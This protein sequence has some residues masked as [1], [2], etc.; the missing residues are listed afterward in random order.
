MTKLPK[1]L[2]G[3][4]RGRS[5]TRRPSSFPNAYRAAVVRRADP[6]AEP[7]DRAIGDEF[8]DEEMADAETDGA[9]DVSV[10]LPSKRRKKTDGEKAPDDREPREHSELAA[11]PK[12][13]LSPREELHQL[14]L[15][16]VTGHSELQEDRDADAD[17]Q[18]AESRSDETRDKRA[19]AIE[20]S[21]EPQ[22]A[23]TKTTRIRKSD[24]SSVT[25]YHVGAAA[26]D[27][28]EG[29]K[30]A[31]AAAPKARTSKPPA[32]ARRRLTRESNNGGAF[33]DNPLR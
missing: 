5:E 15:A 23:R 1:F 19:V 11:R 9:P 6:H 8:L 20:E 32:P 24:G 4:P 2:T 14:F 10:E 13:K 17:G 12:T 25:V 3:K 30:Q 16:A 31:E 21:A 18:R 7:M 27:A 33:R 22:P 29:E 26:R 28:G